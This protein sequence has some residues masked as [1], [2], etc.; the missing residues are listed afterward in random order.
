MIHAVTT[1]SN[2]SVTNRQNCT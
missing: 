1:N 2:T